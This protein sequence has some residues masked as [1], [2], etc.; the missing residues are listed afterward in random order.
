MIRV[1]YHAALRKSCA[2]LTCVVWASAP[3]AEPTTIRGN[4]HRRSARWRRCQ[5]R[6]V[7]SP[8]GLAVATAS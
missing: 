1:E 6:G 7:N 4:T 3:D 2:A 5:L 8:A